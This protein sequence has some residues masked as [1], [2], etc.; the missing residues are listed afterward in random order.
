M[1]L[2]DG[3]EVKKE[4][5]D[6]IC[7][8]LVGENIDAEEAIEYV[9]SKHAETVLAYERRSKTR[10]MTKGMFVKTFARLFENIGEE[11]F[12]ISTSTYVKCVSILIDEK[13]HVFT[14]EEIEEI[15]SES[16]WD[17]FSVR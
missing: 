5:F 3:L 2:S 13:N 17:V 11:V 16:V 6:I 4:Y 8:A 10:F 12:E 1:K 15:D 9:Y 14:K 7:D